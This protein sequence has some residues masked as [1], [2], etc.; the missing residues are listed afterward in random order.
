ML[1][2]S[3][4]GS[5]AG[6]A[7]RLPEKEIAKMFDDHCRVKMADAKKEKK[8]DPQFSHAAVKKVADT[9]A[10]IGSDTS[11]EK[12]RKMVNLKNVECYRCLKKGVESK[13]RD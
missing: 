10:S 7:H 4:F 11:C 12:A 9:K 8:R 6:R 13:P 1:K 2:I 3:Y 5:T